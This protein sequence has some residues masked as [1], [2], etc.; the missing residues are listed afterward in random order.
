MSGP[1]SQLIMPA[2]RADMLA[3]APSYGAD[4]LVFN[5]EKQMREY[6]A[7]IPDATKKKVNEEIGKVKDLLKKEDVEAD[8]LRK[9][10]EQLGSA[11]Q[12]IGKIV[13]EAA[14]KEQS[15]SNAGKGSGGKDEKVVDAEVVDEKK[16]KKK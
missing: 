12:E 10:T 6:D 3:K 1:R 5:L 8:V 9:A 16:S 11:A 2:N 14:Q 4:A 13:Y 15:A 7:K